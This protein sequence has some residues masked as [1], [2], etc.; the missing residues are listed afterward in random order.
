ME[1]TETL[2]PKSSRQNPL[3]FYLRTL[4]Y[5]FMA[6]IMRVVAFAPLCALLLFPAGSHWRWLAVLCPVLLIFFILPLRFSFAQ[7]LVQVGKE[8]RFSFDR[9]TAVQ[10]YGEK[11]AESLLHV[12]HIV[13]WSIPLL[14][15]LGVVYY[16]LSQMGFDKAFTAVDTIGYTV[17]AV[18]AAVGNFFIGI[19]GGTAIVPNGSIAEGLTTLLVAAGI[20]LLI[21]A[22]GVMRNSAYRYIWAYAT[23]V[24]KNPHTEARRRLYGRRWKQFWTAMLNLVLWAPALIVLFVTVRGMF[25]DIT[26]ALT[27]AIITGQVN[28]PD[29]STALL[30]MIFAFFVCYLPLLPVRR[31]ITSL[32][33]TRTMRKASAEGDTLPAQELQTVDT[34]ASGAP[35][36]TADSQEDNGY[37]Y[38]APVAEMPYAAQTETTV[39][40]ED[41]EQSYQPRPTD[42][43]AEPAQPV[44]VY[45]PTHTEPKPEPTVIEPVAEQAMVVAPELPIEEENMP[46]PIAEVEDTREPEPALEPEAESTPVEEETVAAED[47]DAPTEADADEE[48]VVDDE[49][50]GDAQAEEPDEAAADETFAPETVATPDEQPLPDAEEKRTEE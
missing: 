31:I 16:G 18:L 43:P 48:P 7:A 39:P 11:L 37:T 41:E 14:A 32:F 10:H 28:L 24:D 30:P 20:G 50:L 29:L 15:L 3:T 27:T 33:A 9:A 4:L 12:L 47:T 22:W 1:T 25:S 6:L 21:L 5:M 44:P 46:E 2:M 36:P 17:T 34:T 19:F 8:R 49:L 40:M 38:V 26:K 35:I 45:T 42:T 23:Q 13:L